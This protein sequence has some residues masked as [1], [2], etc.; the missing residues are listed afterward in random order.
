MHTNLWE[1]SKVVSKIVQDELIQT[2]RTT[3]H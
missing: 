3:F 1:A 2:I